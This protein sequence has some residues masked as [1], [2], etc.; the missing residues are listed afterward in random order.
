MTLRNLSLLFI[1]LFILAACGGGGGGSTPTSSPSAASC[2]PS[3]TNLCITVRET[4]GGAYGGSV[5]RDYV[6]QNSTS[7]GVANKTLTLNAGTYVFDQTDSTN[8]ASALHPLRISTTADGTHGGGS[9]YTTG[10]TVTGTPGTDG[11]TTIVINAQTPTTLYYYCSS[12]AGMGGQ[13]NI[14]LGNQSGQVEFTET[15]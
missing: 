10:V 12:H 1:S 8:A 5:S 14:V 11:K 6:V 15:Q 4:G 7:A 3:T 13:I 2:S 9:E